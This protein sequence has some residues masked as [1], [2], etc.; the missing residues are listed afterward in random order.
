MNW[1]L[2]GS[3]SFFRLE[4]NFLKKIN[5]EIIESRYI[6]LSFRFKLE[7]FPIIKDMKLAWFKGLQKTP[8]VIIFDLG[9]RISKTTFSISLQSWVLVLKHRSW[10]AYFWIGN[11][12]VKFW[13]CYSNF[14]Y[15]Y[16][17]YGKFSLLGN[18][19]Y[20]IFFSES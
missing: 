4:Y 17:N 16:T 8:I 18:A 11:S 10:K 13:Y 3:V 15:C 12:V 2:S 9:K 5:V 14:W 20:F 6:S 7:N 1:S 19:S